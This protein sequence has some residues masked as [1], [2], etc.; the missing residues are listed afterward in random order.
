MTISDDKGCSVPWFHPTHELEM[1]R[2][3]VYGRIQYLNDILVSKTP[4]MT[5]E[6]A[7]LHDTIM[8]EL[9]FLDTIRN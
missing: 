9:R 1:V 4:V 8:D 5:D 2:G 6:D 3:L 7:V